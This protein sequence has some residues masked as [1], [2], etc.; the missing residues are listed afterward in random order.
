MMDRENLEPELKELG[1]IDKLLLV[2]VVIQ[3]NRLVE[4]L[5]EVYTK[6]P[7]AQR[8]AIA[9]AVAMILLMPFDDAQELKMVMEDIN[10]K[11]KDRLVNKR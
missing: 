10:K 11:L 2:K 1:I 5:K 8:K 9:Y 4:V 6:K 3:T 7:E